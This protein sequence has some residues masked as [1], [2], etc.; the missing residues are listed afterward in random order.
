MVAREM[1]QVMRF[2]L[3]RKRYVMTRGRGTKLGR[4]LTW[5]LRG[6]Q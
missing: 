4:V 3:R 1:M 6:R 5:R 2:T